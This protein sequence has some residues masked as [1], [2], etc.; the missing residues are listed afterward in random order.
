MR[1][2]ISSLGKSLVKI[3]YGA[4]IYPLEKKW[5]LRPR[6]LVE[7]LSR[8]QP[9][10]GETGVQASLCPAPQRLNH[11]P[12]QHEV[13][14]FRWYNDDDGMLV[15]KGRRT[16]EDEAVFLKVM[17]AWFET[18]NRCGDENDERS[19]GMGEGSPGNRPFPVIRPT[20]YFLSQVLDT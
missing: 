12:I 17:A 1:S 7:L 11:E 18:V 15:F 9:V 2:V 8:H 20:A 5:G 3:N 13:R 16:P 6:P 10:S 14:E 19:P 4:S